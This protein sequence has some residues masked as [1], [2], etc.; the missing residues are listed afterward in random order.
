M[1]LTSNVLRQIQ[2][3]HWEIKT[4][5]TALEKHKKET[6]RKSKPI[7]RDM[8]VPKINSTLEKL[9]RA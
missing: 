2:L 1:G 9:K 5:T 6:L 4:T 3:D 8:V 7:I